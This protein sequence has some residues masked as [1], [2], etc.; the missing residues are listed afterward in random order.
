MNKGQDW[1][2]EGVRDYLTLAEDARER[3]ITESL[4][5]AMLAIGM[6]SL[7]ETTFSEVVSRVREYEQVNGFFWY[8]PVGDGSL[9][10]SEIPTDAIYRRLG[11]RARVSPKN[12]QQF[13]AMIKRDRLQKELHEAEQRAKSR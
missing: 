11:M 3:G 7:T 8:A 2:I 1:T 9:A 6:G 12:K 10:L 4:A 5:W 13:R